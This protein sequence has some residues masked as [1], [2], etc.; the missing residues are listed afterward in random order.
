MRAVASSLIIL[1]LAACADV[2]TAEG[3]PPGTELHAAIQRTI[4]ADSFRVDSQLT[5]NGEKHSGRGAYVA[6]DRFALLSLGPG[7]AKSIVVGRDYYVSDQNHFDRFSFWKSPCDVSLES[8]VPALSLALDASEVR[9]EEGMFVFEID[10]TGRGTARI[11]NGY[12]VFLSLRH[13]LQFVDQVDERYTFSGFGAELQIEPPTSDQVRDKSLIE[14][15]GP[16]DPYTGSPVRCE[17]GQ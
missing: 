5:W 1:T 9:L 13:K 12:L 11:E 6:P 14:D 15:T 4:D 17:V 7:A 2:T 10:V 16:F 3:P 8:F